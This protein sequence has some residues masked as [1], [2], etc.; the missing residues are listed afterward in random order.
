ME[1][2]KDF[3]NL[4]EVDKIQLY[5]NHARP[6]LNKQA[7]FADGT[8]FYR[9]YTKNED[10]Y[11]VRLRFRTERDNVENVILVTNTMKKQMQRV[12]SDRQFDYY[13]VEVNYPA[14]GQ[15]YYYQ[16]S[17][18]KMS[19]VYNKR[20]VMDGPQA[21][22]NFKFRPEFKTPDWAKGAVFY[23][24]FVDRFYNG[25]PSNDVL[26]HEYNYIR[27]HTRAE[28]DWGAWPDQLDVQHF[29]G[30]D[31]QGVMD[32]LDYLQNLGVE[33]LYLNPIF[34]SPSN[35][36]YDIQDYDYID[37][38][39]GKIVTD[40][41]D[42]LEEGDTDNRHAT[43]YIRRVTDKANLEASNALF[44]KFVEEVHRRGMRVILDGVFNHCGSFNKW[45]DRECI[46][47]KQPGYE[48]GA[49]VAED[50]PYNSF[51]KF[52]TKQWP[53]NRDYDGWWG[54]ETLPKLNYEESEKL[55]QY[56]IDIGRK[57]VSPPYNVDGWRLDVA[58]DLGHSSEFNHQFWRDFRKAVKEVNPDALILAE[59]YTDPAEWLDG[60]QWD[61]VMNYEAFMEPVSW[62]LTGVE[63][64]SDEY[65]EDLLSNYESFQGAMSHH[66][67]RFH[68]ESLYTAMNELS[69]HDHSRF[70]TRTSRQVGRLHTKGAK[71]AN[72]GVNKAVMREAVVMQM[73]WPG[74]P[75][76]YYGDEAGVCGWTDPDNR[77][78]YP[79]GHE[80]REMLYFHKAAIQIHRGSS[81]LRTG[82]F[83][84]MYGERGIVAYGRFDQKERYVVVINNRNENVKIKVPVWQIGVF[85]GG[86]MEQ[87]LMSIEDA[88][89]RVNKT[90]GVKDG[91]IVI[92][93]PK[94]SAII[95]KEM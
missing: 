65:R 59:N 7:L 82:S 34:V 36:K 49:F 25:D 9:T 76:I 80:D 2:R 58:A 68:H 91:H 43:R 41:G 62:F 30:G 45:M 27:E 6:V 88:I 46:Y 92:D 90:F 47:E 63:K 54:H 51:F 13:E 75:T 17:G 85:N 83:K 94:T 33:V 84:L 48:D 20:G 40:D 29:Y 72:V 79:W 64:H 14:C 73:T 87:L 42:L 67:S 24:I 19:A 4:P 21:Y 12:M 28:K 5:I 74:A 1:M 35:H 18:G 50:S 32:K 52:R 3:A 16:V 11:T 44:I 39:F 61:T 60:D 95:L 57:W 71:A 31:L 26:D 69:N 66:M 10:G 8:D 37:P 53:Y 15:D 81:A 70:L 78:T 93:M 38:H 56:I 86:R 55:Y 89:T 77:R 23:Q 22:Y